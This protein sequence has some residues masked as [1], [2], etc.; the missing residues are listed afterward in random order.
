MGRRA[1]GTGRVSPA[2]RSR[3]CPSG[4]GGAWSLACPAS[5]RASS[6]ARKSISSSSLGW[7]KPFPGGGE[8]PSG[9]ETTS[10]SLATGGFQ[11]GARD[12][13]IQEALPRPRPPFPQSLLPGT[14]SLGTRYHCGSWPSQLPW[15]Q[16]RALWRPSQESG[17]DGGVR[18]MGRGQEETGKRVGEARGQCITPPSECLPR[19]EGRTPQGMGRCPILYPPPLPGHQKEERAAAAPGFWLGLPCPC[20]GCHSLDRSSNQMP[21]LSIHRAEQAPLHSLPGTHYARKPLPPHPHP[22]L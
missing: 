7:G 22:R 17:R 1:G 8:G 6:W 14:R 13:P 2:S 20:H 4:W 9:G 10:P 19:Q 3:C 5:C 16:L 12:R 18:G 21:T 11:E 15:R